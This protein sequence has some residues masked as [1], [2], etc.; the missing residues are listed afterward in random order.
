MSQS[1][2][3]SNRRRKEIRDEIKAFASTRDVPY[4]ALIKL[5]PAESLERG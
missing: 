1:R 5:L 3:V 2:S 4:Q